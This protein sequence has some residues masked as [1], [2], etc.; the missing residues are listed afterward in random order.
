M[1]PGQRGWQAGAGLSDRKELARSLVSEERWREAMGLDLEAGAQETS[2]DSHPLWTSPIGFLGSYHLLPKTEV[3]PPH[4]R[5][6]GDQRK[7]R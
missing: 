2:T 5:S 7:Y 4:T 6:S 1:L 3:K